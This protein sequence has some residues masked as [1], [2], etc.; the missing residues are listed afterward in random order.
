MKFIKNYLVLISK[1]ASNLVPNSTI[2]LKK[3]SINFRVLKSILFK[4]VFCWSIVEGTKS[5][6]KNLKEEQRFLN[7]LKQIKGNPN[8]EITMYQ[9]APQRDLREGDI[10][11]PFLSDAQYY[12]DESKITPEEIREAD[13]ARRRQ[14]QIDKTSAV[15][16]RQE[17]NWHS[18]AGVLRH[19][20]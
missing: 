10:I 1:V 5:E 8:A 13:R 11:T 19:G 2:S 7:K 20:A 15:N 17:K 4:E 16:L 14:E 6:L 3:V 18:G 12:V 9:A